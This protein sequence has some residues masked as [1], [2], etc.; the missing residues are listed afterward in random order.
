LGFLNSLKMLQVSEYM[1]LWIDLGA[2]V[3]AFMYFSFQFLEQIDASKYII[4][5]FN[6]IQNSGH[7]LSIRSMS[8]IFDTPCLSCFAIRYFAMRMLCEIVYN[9]NLIHLVHG[10]HVQ[11]NEWRWTLPQKHVADC[12]QIYT[13]RYV[14]VPIITGVSSR[15]CSTKAWRIYEVIFSCA[16]LNILSISTCRQAYVITGRHKFHSQFF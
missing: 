12:C 13:R 7:C 15:S 4:T 11:L 2:N 3:Y 8:R 5:T 10:Q 6:Y 16:F 14:R 1:F 9:M